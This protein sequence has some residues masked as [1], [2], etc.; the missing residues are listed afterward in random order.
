M[1]SDQRRLKL[2]LASFGLALSL[3]LALLIWHAYDQLKFEAFYQ[4][5]G[6]AEVLHRQLDVNLQQL[7]TTVNAVEPQHY[8]F[9][10]TSGAVQQ[11]SPLASFPVTSSLPGVIGYFEVDDQG[12]YSSPLLPQQSSAISSGLST[13]DQQQRQELANRLR[14]ILVDNQLVDGRTS[15]PAAVE[16]IIV[17]QPVTEYGGES[18]SLRIREPDLDQVAELGSAQSGGAVRSEAEA[19]SSTAEYGQRAFDVLNSPSRQ[20][21]A[22]PQS[23]GSHF[24]I[25]LA[26][27]TTTSR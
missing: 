27:G 4:F 16:E 5:R 8:R 17:E 18:D 15:A 21:L 12:G 6:Q 14:T 13:Q 3:P 2:V 26:I 11:R 19:P 25:R 9:F 23:C 10:N 1:P 24:R 20:R 7:M 22:E